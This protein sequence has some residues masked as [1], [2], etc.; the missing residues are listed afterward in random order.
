[1]PWTKDQVIEVYD[2]N[3][4]LTLKKLSSWSGLDVWELLTILLEDHEKK[5][6]KKAQS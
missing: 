3:P 6:C 5:Q 4:N 2:R 1:M